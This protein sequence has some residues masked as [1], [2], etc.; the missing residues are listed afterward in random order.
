MLL[1]NSD[2]HITPAGDAVIPCY[3]GGDV[4]IY[5][6][7]NC[8]SSNRG[9]WKTGT[10]MEKLSNANIISFNNYNDLLNKAIELWK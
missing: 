7:P 10:W 3:F 4:L 8:I 1:A 6:C 2:K 9:V 5:N